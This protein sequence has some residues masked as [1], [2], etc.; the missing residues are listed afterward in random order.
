MDPY[1]ISIIDDEESIRQSV[2][3]AL[4]SQYRVSVFAAAEDGIAA[5]EEGAPDLVLLDIGL[6]GMNGIEALQ[7]IMARF[8]EMAVVMITAYEDVQTVVQAMRHGAQD[9][10]VKPLSG[11]ELL[12]TI[13]N[14]MERVRLRREL[15][16]LQEQC[17]QEDMPW[18]LGES[19]ALQG[20]MEL[21][22][23]VAKSPDT[24]VLI[25][26][27]TGSGKE[28]VARAVHFRSPNFQGPFVAVNCAAIPKELI[29]SEL[30]GYEAG[31]FSGA[32]PGGKKGLIEEAHGGTLFLDEIGDLLPEA[33]AKLLRYLDSGEFFRIGAGK[34]TR[35][36]ARIVSATNHNLKEMVERKQ[37]RP[38]LYYRLGVVTI[39]VPSLNARR[40]DILPL[41]LFFLK[42][43]SIKFG[44][45]VEDISAGA[46]KLLLAHHFVGNVRELKNMIE[47]GVLV[48]Q[49]RLLEPLDISEPEATGSVMARESCQ[50]G[51]PPLTP[52]GFDL[53]GALHAMERHFIEE[54]LR[55]AGGNES[56]AA[57][58]LR[59]N[60]HTFR[61]R[62]K[63]I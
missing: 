58:L 13:R 57:R 15:F 55:H 10:V 4:Q 5:M 41:A 46:R 19:G 45:K 9:Y 28:L 1:S 62:K 31:A 42:R 23:M 7:A 3:L 27:E 53:E 60:H 37:F 61:Y 8:P 29:E 56:M 17:L 39:Q 63:K 49:G 18:C 47:R 35:V 14:A 33:Q 51:Y 20:V 54:A 11:E 40:A 12:Q 59:M 30:F 22:G 6:P 36:Q 16:V 43:F 25:M 52:A 32:R 50:E 44:K 24:P 2:R 34:S 21:V 38:D 48:S 26:G